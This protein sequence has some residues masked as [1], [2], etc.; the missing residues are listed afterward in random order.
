MSLLFRF[1]RLAVVAGLAEVGVGE[2][3]DQV[4]QLVAFDLGFCEF[5][6]EHVLELGVLALDG[7]HGVVDQPAD[8][9]HFS[10]V[11]LPGLFHGR[12][13]LGGSCARSRRVLPARFQRHPEDVLL[14]VVVAHLQL[15]GEILFVLVG[16]PVFL[17][18]HVVVVVGVLE[19]L[20]QFFLPF[21]ERVRHVLQKDQAQHHVLVD[22]E[23][24][25]LERSLSAAV[26]SFFS[27]SLKNCCSWGSWIFP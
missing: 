5:L 24:S 6:V 27:R 16:T 26:Q 25:R 12:A 3:G 10:G 21:F 17:G 4:G 20:A 18:V 8:G 15:G 11:S 1:K 7:L 22:S 23:A 9:A 2:V 14:G 13:H 19:L